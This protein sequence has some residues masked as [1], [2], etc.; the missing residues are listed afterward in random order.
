MGTVQ[1]E[2]AGYYRGETT[3]DEKLAEQVKASNT[4]FE[5]LVALNRKI[6]RLAVQVSALCEESKK[7]T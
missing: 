5:E 7:C 6:N 2:N 3:A 4:S 1:E